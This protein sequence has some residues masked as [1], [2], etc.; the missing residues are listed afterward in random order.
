MSSIQPMRILL[1]TGAPTLPQMLGGSQRSGDTLL[2][3]L[4]NRGHKVA[5]SAGLNGSGWLGFRGRV[6]MKVLR[7]RAIKDNCLGYPTYR[8]WFVRESALEVASEFRPDVV[9]VMAHDTGRVAKAF[10]EA[11][12]PVLFNFQDVEFH[13]HGLDLAELGPVRGV[14]NSKF[15]ASA[16]Q[17]KFGAVCSVIN[18]MIEPNRYRTEVN[19]EYVT[20]INPSPVK[21]L[22][23]AIDVAKLLPSINFLF[24]ETWPLPKDDRAELLTLLA[25]VPNVTL[26]ARVE[27]MRQVYSKTRILLCPSQWSEGYGRIATEAQLSGIPVVGSDRGGLPEA[28]G[29]GGIIVSAQADAE[30]WARE[31]DR[32]WDNDEDWSQLS[33]KAREYADRDAMHLA[34][35]LEQ[36]ES[37]ISRTAKSNNGDDKSS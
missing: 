24:Q 14:G 5:I 28:I 32:L 25:D 12:I 3:G 31:I 34:K 17:E 8:S 2:R 20:F 4:Q 15:T 29:S 13:A 18:P 16:Y 21:G 26:G 37:A 30:R 33:T 11:G 1:A 36:W 6:L 27:D 19:G 10:Y 23:I 35:Q 22:Q 9:V 7:R